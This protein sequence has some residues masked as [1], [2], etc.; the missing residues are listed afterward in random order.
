MCMKWNCNE[1]YYKKCINTYVCSLKYNVSGYKPVFSKTNSVS[2]FSFM[3]K[4]KS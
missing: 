3:K 4:R 1:F 2:D